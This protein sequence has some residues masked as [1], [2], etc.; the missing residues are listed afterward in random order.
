MKRLIFHIDVNSAFLSWS[1]V[2]RLQ[3]DPS[4]LDL[5]TVPSAVGGDIRTRHGVITA[6]SIPASRMGVCTGEPVVKALQKCPGL[7][8][9]PSDFITYRE[10]SRRFI[11]ILEEYSEVLEQ[12][13]ID[14][15][16][17]DM[18]GRCADPLAA[19]EE[20][21][22]RIRTQLGFTVNV[23]I[24]E[25][26][27]LAKM[28]SDF[29]KP[30]KTHTLYPEEVPAKMWPLPIRSLY[31]CG[32]RSAEK[33]SQLGITT[34][35]AAAAADPRFLQDVLGDKAGTYIHNSANGI[36]T[37]PV[38]AE[39]EKAKSYSNEI[40]LPEDISAANYDQMMPRI[41]TRLSDKVAGRLA[42]DGVRSSTVSVIVKTGGFRRHTR[43]TMLPSATNDPRT[44]EKAARELMYRLAFS[45][46][47]LFAAD[48]TIRLVGIG[49]SGLDDGQFRQMGLEE[50]LRDREKLSQKSE[51]NKKLDAMLHDIER[52]YGKGALRKGDL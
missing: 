2:K 36:S 38:R 21:R 24:S 6:K 26:K 12:V 34:I 27:L 14:E 40:T 16:Y 41:L 7:I 33:L 29:E 45:E 13:S 39:E 19:A 25:N 50:W 3:E 10:F 20:I 48:E 4:C 11:K 28:A 18:T 51:K 37:S 42:K 46:D 30:D 5:R 32:P 1:A 35:G 9:V 8:L 47:G 15:A 22:T 43:Q 52:K 23:G 49:C 17:L 31:G 44:I